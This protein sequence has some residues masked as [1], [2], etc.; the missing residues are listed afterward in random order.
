MARPLSDW[1][2]AFGLADKGSSQGAPNK[3]LQLTGAIASFSSSFIASAW[4][5]IARPS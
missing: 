5:L 1:A 3:A 4:M 2:V